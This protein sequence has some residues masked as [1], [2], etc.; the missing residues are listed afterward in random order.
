MNQCPIIAHHLVGA[1]TYCYGLLDNQYK[2]LL[3]F[4]SRWPI[5]IFF[6]SWSKKVL[7]DQLLSTQGTKYCQI[8]ISLI[9][10]W[11]NTERYMISFIK[12][13]IRIHVWINTDWYNNK[14]SYI[15]INLLSNNTILT[16]LDPWGHFG[17]YF[18]IVFKQCH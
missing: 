2:L 6:N 9:L 1:M 10:A 12:C 11:Y 16:Y 7:E 18:D 8:H 3:Q 14:V 15:K 17:Y 4:P 13:V 5:P